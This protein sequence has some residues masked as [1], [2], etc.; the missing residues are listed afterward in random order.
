MYVETRG[1]FCRTRP[2]LDIWS[3][4]TL[5][6]RASF[7]NLTALGPLQSLQKCPLVID[8]RAFPGFSLSVLLPAMRS[9][10]GSTTQ[11]A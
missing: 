6:S 4:P 3:Q 9:R 1:N 10:L 7:I 2:A 11:M 5:S 8:H